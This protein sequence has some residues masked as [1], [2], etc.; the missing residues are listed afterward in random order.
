MSRKQQQRFDF[1]QAVYP[2]MRKD[3]DQQKREHILRINQDEER[4]PDE[5]EP[6]IT[7]MR[8]KMKAER[9][10]KARLRKLRNELDD[11]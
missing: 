9:E 5:E 3:E 1:G 8:E 6:F 10:A 2:L 11:G 7:A 4:D